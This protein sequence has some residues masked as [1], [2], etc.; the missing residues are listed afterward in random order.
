MTTPD[1]RSRQR[2]ERH[3]AR[4]I[5]FRDDAELL[6][7]QY[8]KPDSAGA[9][10]YESAKQCINALANLAGRNP[11]ATGAKTAFLE[12]VARQHPGYQNALAAGWLAASR[13]HIHADR[14]NLDDAQFRDSW[15]EAQTF[16]ANLLSIYAA[17]EPLNPQR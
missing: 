7:G 4:A 14:G 5:S 6:L 1:N 10:L 9:L 11:G 12:N 16:I 15:A 13:L 17:A 3:H 8:D 2:A